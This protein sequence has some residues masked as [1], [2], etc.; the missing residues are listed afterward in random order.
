MAI[1]KYFVMGYYGRGNFGDD[2]MLG[3]L[4]DYLGSADR[5]GVLCG[6][7][8]IL[9]GRENIVAVEKSIKSMLVAIRTSGCI[10]QAGGTIF[11]DSYKGRAYFRYMFILVAYAVIFWYARFAGK[12]V[13]MVGVGFGPLKSWLSRVIAKITLLACDTVIV[14]DF[15]SQRE[16]S[17]LLGLSN[18]GKI[19]LGVDLTFLSHAHVG[20]ASVPSAEKSEIT[21]G[22]SACDLSP[23]LEADDPNS[24][25][26]NLVGII[27]NIQKAEEREVN[28]KLIS[29]YEGDSSLPDSELFAGFLRESGLKNTSIVKYSG[30]V[31]AMNDE[32]ASCDFLIA[33][34]FHAVVSAFLQGVPVLAVSYN[35]KVQDFCEENSLNFIHLNDLCCQKICAELVGGLLKSECGD[36]SEHLEYAKNNMKELMECIKSNG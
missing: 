21:I 33:A 10:V 11:H 8:S 13:Y 1:N 4:L 12:K 2:F 26:L 3:S 28:I 14:R 34:K 20:A 19:L 30:S 5:I 36:N 27:S 9:R 23:F 31:R 15:A 6:D 25:W 35:R 16:V 22:L 32:I 24:L 18:I 17:S 29:L 7:D